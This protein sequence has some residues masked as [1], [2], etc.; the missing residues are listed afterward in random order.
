MTN[1]LPTNIAAKEAP[2]IADPSKPWIKEALDAGRNVPVWIAAQ[3]TKKQ[4]LQLMGLRE[5]AFP[6]TEARAVQS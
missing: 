6:K 2:A 4:F 1:Q 5:R 3:P